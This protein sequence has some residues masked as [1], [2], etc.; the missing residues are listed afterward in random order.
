MEKLGVLP[1]NCLVLEDSPKGLLSAKKAGMKCFTLPT[2]Y[3][4]NGDFSLADKVL[5]S[6]EDVYYNLKNNLL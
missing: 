6:L 1:E 5:D 2:P 4:K 3:V